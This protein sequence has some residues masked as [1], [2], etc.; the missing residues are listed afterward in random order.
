MANFNQDPYARPF[1]RPQEPGLASFLQ[2]LIGGEAQAGQAQLQR[3]QI[4]EARTKAQPR[5]EKG[6]TPTQISSMIN[7]WTRSYGQPTDRE[8][9]VLRT[10]QFPSQPDYVKGRVPGYKY[11]GTEATQRGIDIGAANRRGR[12]DLAQANKLSALGGYASGKK[13]FN[14][15]IPFSGERGFN[16]QK[17]IGYFKRL[18]SLKEGEEGTFNKIMSELSDIKT[19]KGVDRETLRRAIDEKIT[20]FETA[21][22]PKT[23]L[24]ETL[25]GLYNSIFPD[26]GGTQ[27]I[28][29]EP[30][31]YNYDPNTGR[32]NQTGVRQ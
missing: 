15:A 10:G 7:A 6:P 31:E 23:G 14:T 17:T 11:S 21:K 4:E 20:M 1:T 24:I 22:V 28:Q 2:G 13:Y 8:L 27:G 30:V 9:G 25:R 26:T 32:Y 12:A 19:S 18:D 16:P 5:P 29:G 3:A